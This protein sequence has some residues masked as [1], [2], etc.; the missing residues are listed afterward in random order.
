MKLNKVEDKLLHACLLAYYKI[1]I[2]INR[3]TISCTT[4]MFA[5]AFASDVLREK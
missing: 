2:F 3:V 4:M 1:R 5:L